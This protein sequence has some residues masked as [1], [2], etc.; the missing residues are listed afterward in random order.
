MTFDAPYFKS[1]LPAQCRDLSGA[2][3]V[4]L[5]LHDGREFLVRSVR[6]AAAGYV[7]LDIY[8]PQGQARGG[9]EFPPAVSLIELPTYPTALAYEAIQ[10]VFL[11]A[12][13]PD[14]AGRL[15]FVVAQ[16]AP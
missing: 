12:A 14:A 8:A 11:Q 7:L 15:G 4:R 5:I 1:A 13:A 9:F 16:P 3:V 6:E 10:Q 2:P